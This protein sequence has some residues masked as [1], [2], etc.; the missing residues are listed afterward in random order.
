[1]NFFQVNQRSTFE[2]EFRSGYLCCPEGTFGGWQYMM[3]LRIGDIILHYNSPRQV[4][5]GISRVIAIGRHKG[6]AADSAAQRP[7]TQCIS[8]EG[9]HLSEDD[10]PPKQVSHYRRY[11]EVHTIPCIGRKLPKPPHRVPQAYL[12]PI[13]DR[14]ALNYLNENGISLDQL[15]PIK[16]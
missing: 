13:P 8:Y 11:F 6:A 12:V 16:A 2:R 7:G 3:A 9:H 10:F 5:L 1:M 14:E 4:V 15:H